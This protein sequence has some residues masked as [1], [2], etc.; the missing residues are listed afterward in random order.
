MFF[1]IFYI[2][3]NMLPCHSSNDYYRIKIVLK[4]EINDPSYIQK[5]DNLVADTEKCNANIFS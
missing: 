4:N 5:L 1:I 3:W 2:V